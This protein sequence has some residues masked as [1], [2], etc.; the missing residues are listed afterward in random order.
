MRDQSRL[1][2]SAIILFA[3]LAL[4]SLTMTSEAFSQVRS[5]IQATARVVEAGP[6]WAAHAQV[7]EAT[8]MALALVADYWVPGDEVLILDLAESP[9]GIPRPRVTLVREAVQTGLG[10]PSQRSAVDCGPG[11]ASA[12]LVGIAPRLVQAGEV[13]AVHPNQ[14]RAARAPEL[15]PLHIII[16]VEHISN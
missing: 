3:V 1:Q 9:A 8:D 11:F 13:S 7:R 12:S 16:Y 6:G 4:L 2:V 10:C 15:A 5:T 14:A